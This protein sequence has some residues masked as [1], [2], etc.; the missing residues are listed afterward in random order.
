MVDK[1]NPEEFLISLADIKHICRRNRKGIYFTITLFTLLASLYTLTKPLSYTAEASFREKSR[2]QA[3][4]KGF[5][6]FLTG[7][8]SNQE[9]EAASVMRS[10]D[11]ISTMI[12]KLGL[13]ANLIERG[14]E[15]SKLGN[16]W[17]NLW[18]EYANLRDWERPVFKEPASNLI[19]QD[20]VY[21]G[22]R[23]LNLTLTFVDEE[24]FIIKGPHIAEAKRSLSE[25]VVE[26]EFE[27]VLIHTGQKPI[28]GSV[29]SLS[30][31][32]LD[33][34][35]N[36][37]SKRI[38]VKLDKTDK[39]LLL[40]S[41]SHPKRSHAKR[42]VNEIMAAYQE[43]LKDEH[44]R[45]AQIQLEYLQKRQEESYQKQVELMEAHAIALSDDISV[46]GIAD[47]EKEME[48]FLR[49]QQQY[50]NK[51]DAVILEIKRLQH[52]VDTGSEESSLVV[53]SG[54]KSPVYQLLQNTYELKQQ[55]DALTLALRQNPKSHSKELESEFIKQANDLEEICAKSHE[56]EIILD[57][58]SKN[59]PLDQ[60][61]KVFADSQ[62]LI[63][64]WY[65][66][67]QQVSKEELDRQK[68]QFASYL[69]NLYRLFSVH[70]KLIEERI[71]HHSQPQKQFEGISL[72][73]ANQLFMAY[74]KEYDRLEA[75]IKKDAFIL[76]QMNDPE[77]EICSLASVLDDSVSR[78]I[79]KRSSELAL[80][81]RD[82]NNRSL[83]EHERVK[84]ELETQKKFLKA[85]LEQSVQVI[86]L[87]SDL[88]QEKMVALQNIMVNL[89]HQSI[90][91]MQKQ[92]GDFIASRLEYLYQ[93]QELINKHLTELH[94]KMARI[95]NRWVWEQI[96]KRTL[97]MN[98]SLAEE[99]TR[100]VEGKNI[101]HHLEVIQ[102]A[103][104][105]MAYASL[106]PDSPKIILFLA[107]GLALG[108]FASISFFVGRTIVKGIPVSEDNLKLAKQNVAGSISQNVEIKDQPLLDQDLATLRR[109]TSFMKEQLHK[110]ILLN[111]GPYLDYIPTL[112]DLL[113]RKGFKTML[114]PLTFNQKETESVTGL[115][116]YL[117]DQRQKPHVIH[118]EGFDRISPGGVHRFG[119]E[120]ISSPAFKNLLDS[121]KND[122]DFVIATTQFSPSSAEAES[123]IKLFDA[124]VI[125]LS[126]E[127][128]TE[129]SFYFN[130]DKPI[131]FVFEKE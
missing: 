20:L 45:A 19:I 43:F 53:L 27:F 7:V 47:T 71:A 52:S 110:T 118:E 82:D 84:S 55:R 22:D 9:S 102:S 36:K 4:G 120:L 121:F 54:D 107:I 92:I 99:I 21:T 130:L 64:H 113:H 46:T 122:Y 16:I 93:E 28:A 101:S 98:Q 5:T 34:L 100:M 50:A 12:R 119:V 125:T 80:L 78:E 51:L 60:S 104:V 69:N 24:H 65:Q 74:S 108:S 109:L 38:K 116:H 42:V 72:E 66:K 94:Q 23:T 8:S 86:H 131:I 88:F 56:I 114:I 15:P 126:Q 111:E 57:C 105:D 41:Y 90:S 117:Y 96:V 76:N 77:F 83:K 128:I 95:P 68:E 106:L 10:K 48:F 67:L 14:T 44:D 6:D 59:E 30:L 124:G 61:F 81:L 13:Q 3:G 17:K 97:V 89:I 73:T 129:I 39:T 11:L 32:P 127:K 70:Q 112:L 31:T 91:V 29:F 26:D 37:F 2:A 79:I 18:V 1:K 40:L 49:Q 75:N 63:K 62:L 103:P 33:L 58:L 35:A 85:H 25:K 123:L 87:N 115:L